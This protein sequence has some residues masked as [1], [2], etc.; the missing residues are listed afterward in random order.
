M[1]EQH[2]FIDCKF[3]RLYF[4]EHMEALLCQENP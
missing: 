1:N 4:I 3:V 2:H